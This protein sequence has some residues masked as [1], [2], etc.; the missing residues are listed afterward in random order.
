[1]TKS[2]KI[3]KNKVNL[4][5]IKTCSD[6]WVTTAPKGWQYNSKESVWVHNG[7]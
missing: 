1:M 6:Y 2:L 3:K 7:K 5:Y 4:G